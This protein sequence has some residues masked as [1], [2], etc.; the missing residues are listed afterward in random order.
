MNFLLEIGTEEL[1]NSLLLTT[2]ESIKSAIEKFLKDKRIEFSQIETFTTPRRMTFLVKDLGEKQSDLNLKIVGP[3]IE[4]AYDSEGALTKAGE[5]FLAKN[6][7]EKEQL[8]KVIDKKGE[9][10]A[11]ELF[12]K[13]KS[14]K[15]VL[16]SELSIVIEGVTLKKSMFWSGSFK[17]LRP[18]RFVVA[19]LGTEF[20]NIQLGSVKSGCTT[21]GIRVFSTGELEVTS[22]ENYFKVLKAHHVIVNLEERKAKI[23]SSI[24]EIYP[25]LKQKGYEIQYSEELLTEVANLVEYPYPIIGEFEES[26]LSV[27]KEMLI[28]TMQVHQR[29]FPILDTKGELVNQFIIIR[30]GIE[31]S[32]Y[33]RTGN[34]KV[35]QARLSDAKFFFMED[36]KTP[37]SKFESDLANITFQKQLG[38]VSEKISRI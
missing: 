20:I 18:V 3:K 29:Y 35:V 13:G 8:I 15:E 31:N 24:F 19:I 7:A 30:N 17:F 2:L 4:I 23:L 34:Q 21:R 28:T 32:D 36:L 5:G 9:S 14:T 6:G 27:P 12:E 33:V 25:E 1:P 16:E 11:V 10:I 26:F 37:F 22:I 38:K